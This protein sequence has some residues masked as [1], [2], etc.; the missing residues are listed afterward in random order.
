V[1]GEAKMAE[2]DNRL[3]MDIANFKD[4]ILT[5]P[6]GIMDPEGIHHELA[7]G[8]HGRKLDFDK[9]ETGSDLYLQW[10]SLY[11]R[12]IESQ[13]R[14][15][16]PDA[17]VGIAS[18]ANRLSEDVAPLLG[19]SVLG[20]TTVKIDSNEVTLSEESRAAI[21]KHGVN[22]ALL[23]EDVGTT[24]GTMSTVAQPLTEVGVKR[25]EA[26]MTWRRAPELRRLDERGIPHKSMIYEPLPM[27]TKEEC[28]T[29]PYGYCAGGV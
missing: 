29:S 23:V 27:F 3:K 10:V 26:V 17:L 1:G 21:K 25:I 2:T 7:S 13:Y 28:E 18:G 12:F 8:C 22:F 6:V 15:Q 5:D 4:R 11:A 19:R 14:N 24:G 9:I 20:L 16:L